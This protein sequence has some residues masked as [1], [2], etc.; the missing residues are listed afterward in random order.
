[1]E[2]LG[3]GEAPISKIANRY[4]Y[5]IVIKGVAIHKQIWRCIDSSV[6][7]DMDALN[8]G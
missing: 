1:L 3:F 2:I 5:Q 4:R 8:F 7:V 6:K